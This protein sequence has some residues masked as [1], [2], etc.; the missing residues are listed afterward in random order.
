[1]KTKR[2]RLL[3]IKFAYSFFC[4]MC[5]CVVVVVY[6]KKMRGS[7]RFKQSKNFKTMNKIR[8]GLKPGAL[9]P[10]NVE[11]HK[12]LNVIFIIC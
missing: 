1:M 6:L 4:F 12:I 10:M 9:L 11:E 2:K 8:I 3:Q 5:L 7:N